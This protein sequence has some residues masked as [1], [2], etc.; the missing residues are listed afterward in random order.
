MERIGLAARWH[1]ASDLRVEP[2]AVLDPGPGQALVRM[3]ASGICGS[4]VHAV[5]GTF[6]LWT[7]PVTL[8]HEGVG[9]VEQIGGGDA[10]AAV[11]DIVSVCPSVSC[12]M[13][14]QCREGEELL[15]SRRSAHLGAFADYCTVPVAAL[16]GLPLGTTWRTAV[17]VEPLAC[18]LHA[19]SLSGVRPGEWLGVVGGGT[20]GQLIVQVARQH[21]AHVLL[22]EPDAARREIGTQLGADVVLDPLATDLVAESR[23]LTAGVGMDRVVEAVGRPDTVT[24]AIQLARRGGSVVVMG[25]AAPDAE[26]TVRPYDLYQR[27]LTLRGSFI[28]NFD[29]QRAVRLLGRLELERLVTATFALDEIHAAIDNVAAGHGLK[30]VVVTAAGRS[31]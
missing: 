8:G 3:L 19:L 16:Y 5:R 11:G 13:C 30:T 29:F 26:I 12:G 28:R 18:V 31:A 10:P 22:S 14:Y 15:C 20:I 24:Q 25:V 23:R 27:Q 2:Q 17:F 1:G 21:G 6:N 7:P 4:D 9:V